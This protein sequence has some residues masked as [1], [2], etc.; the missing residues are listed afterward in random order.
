MP[1]QIGSLP[2]T[3]LPSRLKSNTKG[4]PILM[5][6]TASCWARA[7][8]AP[9]PMVPRIAP[10]EPIMAFAPA[11]HGVEPAAFKTVATAKSAVLDRSGRQWLDGCLWAVGSCFLSLRCRGQAD[12]HSADAHACGVKYSVGNGRGDGDDGRF[13]CPGAGQV[14]AVRVRWKSISGTS[15]KRGTR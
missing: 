10:P 12:G 3:A 2:S 6:S 14:G 9:P 4:R 11:L 8:T 7:S 1:P 13:A 15:L 5:A